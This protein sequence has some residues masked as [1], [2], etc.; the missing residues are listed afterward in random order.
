[1]AAFVRANVPGVCVCSFRW[2]KKVALGELICLLRA[3]CPEPLVCIPSP[4]WLI[5]TSEVPAGFHD[6]QSLLFEPLRRH[7]AQLWLCASELT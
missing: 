6:I 3:A 5:I 1:M 7:L 2:V 4:L